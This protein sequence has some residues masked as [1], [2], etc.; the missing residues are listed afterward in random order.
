VQDLAKANA[1]LEAQR[2]EMSGDEHLRREVAPWRDATPEQRLE[3]MAALCRDAVLWLA[4]LTDAERARAT[5][6][7][8]LPDDAIA[9]L[10]T[11]RRGWR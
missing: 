11:L 9:I 7:D 6:P 5:T 3:A 2:R 10:E 1:M 4:R 8:P